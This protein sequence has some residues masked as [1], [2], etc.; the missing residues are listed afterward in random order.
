VKTLS[1]YYKAVAGAL[2]AGLTALGTAAADGHVTK[3]EWIGIAL[4]VLATSTGVGIVTN[5][6][7]P[8]DTSSLTARVTAI[9]DQLP[10]VPLIA[11]A[12]SKGVVTGLQTLGHVV[13]QTTTTAP[14]TVAAAVPDAPDPATATPTQILASVA[15][16]PPLTTTS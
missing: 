3:E 15:E 12:V 2:I 16:V 1:Q 7:S 8:K 11:D 10:T 5:A 6:P 13:E 9:E 14:E 4:A